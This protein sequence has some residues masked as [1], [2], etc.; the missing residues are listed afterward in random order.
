MLQWLITVAD[1]QG[2][3]LSTTHWLTVPITLALWEPGGW[4]PLAVEGRLLAK[5]HL[6]MK[7]QTDGVLARSGDL[8][9]EWAG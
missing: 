4:E 2:A 5:P 1:D 6:P 7:K 9:S 8:A 3:V